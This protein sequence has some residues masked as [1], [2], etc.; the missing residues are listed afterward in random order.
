MEIAEI[1]WDLNSWAYCEQ[2]HLEF[3]FRK[4]NRTSQI[5]DDETY[6]T[7]NIVILIVI[8]VTIL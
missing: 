3:K 5:H 8:I 1:Y 4:L 7:N 2:D 6:A